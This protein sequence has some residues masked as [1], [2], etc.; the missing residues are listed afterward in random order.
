VLTSAVRDAANGA[1]LQREVRERLGIDART[2]SGGEEAALTFLGATSE[3]PRDAPAPVLVIDIG[4]G[5][6]ELVAGTPPAEPADHVSLQI[7]V[8]RQSE[9]HIRSDPPGHGELERLAEDA[10]ALILPAAE[11]FG[12]APAAAVGVAGTPTSLAAIEQELDPYDPNRVNGYVLERGDCELMLARLAAMPL[13]ERRQV[14]G[15]HPD[16]APTIVAGVAILLEVLIAFGLEQIEV[17][18]HD[19]LHGAALRAAAGA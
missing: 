7:G 15:L 5:S 9:R 8:V 1:E 12:A 10:R 14:T 2:I 19:I 17:S 4:G 3:R 11:R 13:A 18:E 6:T 16:R